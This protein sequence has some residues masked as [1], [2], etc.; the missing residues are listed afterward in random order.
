[1]KIIED[2]KND[3]S[4][5]FMNPETGTTLDFNKNGNVNSSQDTALENPTPTPMREPTSQVEELKQVLAN[6]KPSFNDKAELI[7]KLRKMGVALPKEIE[8]TA[9]MNSMKGY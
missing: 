6:R 8:D 7:M 2:A 5:Q 4:A 3:Q 1:M 9:L